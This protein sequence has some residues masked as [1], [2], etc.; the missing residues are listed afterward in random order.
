MSS[1]RRPHFRDQNIGTIFLAMAR[2]ILSGENAPDIPA[3][4][5]AEVAG[6]E[7]EAT[8]GSDGVAAHHQSGA[9]AATIQAAPAAGSPVGT[10]PVLTTKNPPAAA[11]RGTNR[12]TAS[13]SQLSLPLIISSI[14]LVIVIVVAVIVLVRVFSS[15]NT[16]ATTPA[17]TVPTSA[18]G[19]GN[20]T[21]GSGA[22]PALVLG[23]STPLTI[24]TILGTAGT[25]SLLSSPEEAVLAGNGRIFVS[26]TLN[27]R[28][29][30]FDTHGKLVQSITTGPKGPLSAPFSM[31][32]QPNGDILVLDSELGQLLDYSPQGT[33]QRASSTAISLVHARGLA[34][35]STGKILVANT[36]ANAI[37]VLD[38]SFASIQQETA[39]PAGQALDFNQPSAVAYGPDGTAYV[40]D[41]Q[42]S[43][44]IQYS[45]S[46]RKLR[47]LPVAT[48]DTVHS[49]RMLPL[50]DGRLLVTDPRDNKL[51]VFAP[52]AT[53]PQVYALGTAQE[54]LGIAIDG[55]TKLLIT[56]SASN[57][58][59]IANLPAA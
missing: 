18:T 58:V 43:R 40:L 45:T 51:L 46:W 13:T 9:A 3:L 15:S 48:T 21:T 16:T 27:H 37:D 42:N 49:P 14:S 30:V 39:Q 24:T 19:N 52:D 47:T 34:V 1:T 6:T 11:R 26:D 57:Q 23:P 36:P 53:Q 32:R 38:S 5:D 17:I 7:A 2:A 12:A 54:P 20:A 22:T 29:A 44:I 4:T 10:G 50:A 55:S 8:P 59:L 28:I 25:Q 56:C 31:A 35:S 33:L 41:S